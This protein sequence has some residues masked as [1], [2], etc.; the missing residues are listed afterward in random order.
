ML[1]SGRR[2]NIAFATV[3]RVAAVGQPSVAASSQASS[4]SSGIGR[5]IR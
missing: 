4:A 3:M 1:L 5:A 2:C